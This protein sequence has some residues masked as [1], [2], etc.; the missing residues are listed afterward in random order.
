[1][2]C[3]NPDCKEKIVKSITDTEKNL[4]KCITDGLK[5]KMSITAIASTLAI[6]VAVGGTIS[7]LSYR[8]YSRA[9]DRQEELADRSNA[10]IDKNKEAI[11]DNR[12]NMRTIEGKLT[13]LADNQSAAAIVAAEIL[14]TLNSINKKLPDKDVP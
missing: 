11:T 13:A 8:A 1:M 10:A 12:L 9:Q 6:I 14:R 7:G 3:P 5:K 2:D 4:K